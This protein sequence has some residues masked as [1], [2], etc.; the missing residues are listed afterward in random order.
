MH[1]SVMVVA[2]RGCA[3]LLDLVKKREGEVGKIEEELENLRET[4]AKIEEGR[5]S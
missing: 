3:G 5:G 2:E 4:L 1:E